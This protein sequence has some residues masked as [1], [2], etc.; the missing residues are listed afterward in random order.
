[1]SVRGEV[2]KATNSILRPLGLMLG[3]LPQDIPASP[4]DIS[5]DRVGRCSVLSNRNDLLSHLPKN[6]V[7]AEIGVADGDYSNEIL[8]RNQP[9]KLLLVDAWMSRRYAN[10]LVRVKERFAKEIAEGKVEIR[11]GRSVDVLPTLD[12]NSLDLA[13]IDT[14]HEYQTT[15]EE[16]R[17]CDPLM[18]E[19]GHIA[20]HDFC[21]TGPSGNAYGVIKAVYEFC[22]DRAWS[23]R[24]ITLDGD[25]HF[26]FC[27]SR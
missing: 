10:G 24:Y 11:R 21:P 19:G 18:R 6:G 25:G 12:R 3:N 7:V 23:F 22:A 5:P 27:L 4:A 20:G 8:N 26:T 15:L 16:L 9:S 1:M 2:I 17:L 13:Y 14:S